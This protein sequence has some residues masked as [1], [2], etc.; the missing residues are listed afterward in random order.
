MHENGTDKQQL[1]RSHPRYEIR[2]TRKFEPIE[3]CEMFLTK[4]GKYGYMIIWTF[5][6]FLSGWSYTTVA[7]SAWATNIPFNTP[8]IQRCTADDFLG[9]LI[10]Q[11]PQCWN[12][13]MLCVLFFA[14]IVVPFSLLDLKEQVVMHTIL[15]LLRFVTIFVIVVYCIVKLSVGTNECSYIARNV[16]VF[17]N[18][19]LTLE[20][21]TKYGFSDLSDIVL[22]FDPKGWLVSI[23]VISFA[24]LFHQGIP[25]L[26]HP[27]KEKLHLRH[28]MT[29][30]FGVSTLSYLSLGIV[31][32]LLFRANIQETAT[33]NWVSLIH[34]HAPSFHVEFGNMLSRKCTIMHL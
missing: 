29:V 30:M 7:G 1:F 3:L 34:V 26:T 18:N 21:V 27:I 11:D 32:P 22:R 33:L 8:T 9:V 5:N 24:L 13:Y 20:N 28:L 16:S 23:P 12:A 10:P 25:S 15:G 2:L 17:D 31:V 19:T 4:W 14:V 6:C